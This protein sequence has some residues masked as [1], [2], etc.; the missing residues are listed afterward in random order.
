MKIERETKINERGYTVTKTVKT[1]T[2]EDG[3]VRTRDIRPMRSRSHGRLSRF[4]GRAKVVSFT[5][6]DPK[7]TRPFAYGMSALFFVIG[8]CL[9][10]WGGGFTRIMGV[11]F[12]GTGVFAFVDSKK[13]ID[14]VEERIRR[15]REGISE[16]EE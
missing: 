2:E 12:A 3:W 13:D 15:K 6:N 1:V 9:L 5:T 14:A 7:I 16:K 10:L 4:K 11:F 8:V